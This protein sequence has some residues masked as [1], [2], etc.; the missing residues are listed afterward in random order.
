M[1]KPSVAKASACVPTTSQHTSVMVSIGPTNTR[2]DSKPS[3]VGNVNAS[4]SS[5]HPL[6]ALS[7]GCSSVPSVTRNPT[8]YFAN[9]T[10]SFRF[11]IFHFLFPLF[12]QTH[13]IPDANQEVHIIE[14]LP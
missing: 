14:V 3:V 2:L 1:I 5:A 6:L 12:R 9:P 10:T 13:R 8:A 7:E 11:S 4:I